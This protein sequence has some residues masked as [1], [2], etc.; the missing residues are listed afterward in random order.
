MLRRLRPRGSRPAAYSFWGRKNVFTRLGPN[1]DIESQLSRTITCLLSLTVRRKVL[2]C[3]D[4]GFPRGLNEAARVHHAFWWHGG[5]V[6]AC[7]ERAAAD[8]RCR[9]PRWRYAHSRWRK[10]LSRRVPCRSARDGLH[11]KPERGDRIPV[12]PRPC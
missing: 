4:E 7:R 2:A 11:R 3:L 12:C 6:A 5:D 1:S 10:S 9:V 8:A